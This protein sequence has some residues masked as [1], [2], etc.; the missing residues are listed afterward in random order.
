MQSV[1]SEDAE[2]VIRQQMQNLA[3]AI[4]RALLAGYRQAMARQPVALPDW[5]SLQGASGDRFALEAALQVS[6]DARLRFV[7]FTPHDVH[8]LLAVELGGQIE[9]ELQAVLRLVGL[10]GAACDRDHASVA[11]SFAADGELIIDAASIERA[12]DWEQE[13]GS[14][15]WTNMLHISEL[16]HGSPASAAPSL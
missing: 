15:Y 9:P 7:T 4:D 16:A 3:G 12:M 8:A 2:R 6:A 13:H 10:D 11:F 14:A 5:A 1:P